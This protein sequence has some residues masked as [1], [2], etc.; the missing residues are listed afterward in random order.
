MVKQTQVEDNNKQTKRA[1]KM[2]K[3]HDDI[4]EC[5]RSS[6]KINPGFTFGTSSCGSSGTSQ[7]NNDDNDFQSQYQSDG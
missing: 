2:W 4:A 3:Y 5:M 1:R 6:P 7:S